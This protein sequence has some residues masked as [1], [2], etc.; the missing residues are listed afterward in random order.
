MGDQ[1][2]VE[3]IDVVLHEVNMSSN[4]E[5]KLHLLGGCRGVSVDNKRV[6]RPHFSLAVVEKM[7][8]P[9]DQ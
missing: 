4:K 6:Y 8:D 7:W 5:R 9:N 3:E 2:S 1:V